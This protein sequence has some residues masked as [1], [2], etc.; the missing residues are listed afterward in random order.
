MADNDSLRSVSIVVAQESIQIRT[1]LPDAELKDIGEFINQRFDRSAKFQMENRKRLALLAVELTSE[2]FELRKQ[3]RRAKIYY[4]TMEQ[5]LKNLSLLLDEG[6]S[7][8]GID[9]I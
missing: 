8:N 9:N 1:D 2:I 3:L 7:R 5:D 4:E 6:L